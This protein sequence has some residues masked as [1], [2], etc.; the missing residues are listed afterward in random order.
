MCRIS[1]RPP[2]SEGE[3]SSRASTETVRAINHQYWVPAWGK[4]HSPST[5]IEHC[6][7]T[8]TAAGINTHVAETTAASTPIPTAA[9]AIATDTDAKTNTNN[10]NDANDLS[11][12]QNLFFKPKSSKDNGVIVSA[13]VASGVPLISPS[14]PPSPSSPESTSQHWHESVPLQT[15]LHGLQIPDGLTVAD[16]IDIHQEV[17]RILCD[18]QNELQGFKQTA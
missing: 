1:S 7:G 8:G 15:I 18:I 2:A 9:A 11:K 12:F 3:H 13:G 16:L 17:L 10:A 4:Y 6:T 5:A 14:P